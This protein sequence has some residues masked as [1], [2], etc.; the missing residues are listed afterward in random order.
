[1]KDFKNAVY[2]AGIVG[3]GG[4]GF[5]THIKV[6]QK[7]KTL[8]INGAEC[9][10]LIEVDKNIIK[11]YSDRI[12]K[13]SNFLL[14]IDFVKKII[15]CVKNEYADVSHAIK[16]RINSDKISCYELPNIY[17]IGDEVV[18]I[19]EV[20][21]ITLKKGELP[22]NKGLVVLN[23]ET[24]LNIEK[25]VIENKNVTQSYVTVTGEVENGGTYNFPIGYP[26]E[27]ILNLCKPKI[28]NYKVVVGGAMTGRL[29]QI[30]ESVKKTTKAFI[31]LADNHKV[32]QNMEDTNMT[33]LK[34]IM[35]SCS[36]CRACTD[37]CPRNLLGHKVEPHKLMSAMANGLSTNTASLK[38]T[39]GCVS[40]GVCELYACHHDLSPRKMMVAVKSAFAKEGI[41]VDPNDCVPPLSESIYSR[42]PSK[43]LIMHLN[44]TKYNRHLPFNPNL[45]KSDIVRIY[46]NDHI[47]PPCEPIVKVGQQVEEGDLIGTKKEGLHANIHASISGIV[48]EINHKYIIIV[49]S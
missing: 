24:L 28:D 33:H 44:L 15:I 20:T 7:A 31:I 47:G 25:K 16:S 41:K 13:V 6:Q 42:I 4:A 37:L 36:S 39:M 49:K 32:I 14:E 10:P 9:E 29:A 35:A 17:P 11:N 21:G 23:V 8:I 3:S 22:I 5:P 18:L 40:C 34:R 1:M 43:R 48:K 27:K 26:L 38:T 45:Q 46:L 2:D 12:I 19:N 30:D